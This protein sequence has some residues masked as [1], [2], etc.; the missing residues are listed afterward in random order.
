MAKCWG[1]PQWRLLIEGDATI[2]VLVSSSLRRLVG[3]K[4]GLNCSRS[5]FFV[6]LAE[7]FTLW[8]P[9]WSVTVPATPVKLIVAMLIPC[10]GD[11]INWLVVAEAVKCYPSPQPYRLALNLSLKWV[12]GL[13]SDTSSVCGSKF[14]SAAIEFFY[15]YILNLR[16][17]NPNCCFWDGAIRLVWWFLS[18]FYPLVEIVCKEVLRPIFISKTLKSLMALR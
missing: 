16:A 15:D 9:E 6:W 10:L 12:T 13:I 11:I 4:L 18:I 5:S 17:F 14:N 7:L 3:Y 8:L 1:L 2:W